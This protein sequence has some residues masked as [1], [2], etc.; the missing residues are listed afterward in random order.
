MG[1]ESYNWY[2]GTQAG[3]T[4]NTHDKSPEPINGCEIITLEGC[5]SVSDSEGKTIFYTDG[6]YVKNKFNENMPDGSYLN[7]HYS[8][9]QSSLIAKKPGSGNIYYVFTVDYQIGKNGFCYSLV[10]MNSDNSLGAVIEKNIQIMPEVTEKLTA[11]WHANGEDIWI[12]VHGWNN[13]KFFS[14]LLTEDGLSEKPVESS[15]GMVHTGGQ[16]TFMLNENKV[17]YMRVSPDSKKLACAIRYANTVQIFDFDNETGKVSNPIELTDKKYEH[18]YGLEFSPD[19]RFLYLCKLTDSERLYQIDLQY[20]NAQNIINNSVLIDKGTYNEEFLGGIQ[21]GPD[22]KIYIAQFKSKYLAVISDPCKKGLDCGFQTEAIYLENGRCMQGLPN[23]S[24]LAYKS[25]RSEEDVISLCEGETLRLFPG[26]G[27]DEEIDSYLWKGPNGFSSNDKDLL[28]SDVKSF[29][30]GIYTLEAEGRDIRVIKIFNV[31]IHDKPEA[32]ILGDDLLIPGDNIELKLKKY[33]QEYEYLWSTGETSEKIIIEKPGDYWVKVESP[34]GC[35]DTAYHS[36]QFVDSLYVEIAGPDHLCEGDS[37]QLIA[38]PGGSDYKYLWSTGDTS[39]AISVNEPGNY[40]VTVTDETGRY[41]TAS[42]NIENAGK[43][44][45]EIIL[46]DES[47]LCEGDILLMRAY[48]QDGCN[49]IWST[50]E[51]GDSIIVKESGTY[52]LIAQNEYGC[53]N[54][55]TSE[56]IFYPIPELQIIPQ[57]EPVICSNESIELRIEQGYENCKW[58]TGETGSFIIVN[59]T[60]I[61][62]A[63]Y[64]NEHGC[65]AIDSIEIMPVEYKFEFSDRKNDSFD[66]G[67]VSVG[68]TQTKEIFL[69]NKSKHGVLIDSIEPVQ[70]GDA[71]SISHVVLPAELPSNTSMEIILNFSPCHKGIHNAELQVDISEPCEHKIISPVSGLSTIN[72]IVWLPDTTGIIGDD[73]F[74]IPLKA[75]LETPDDYSLLMSYRA[76]IRYTADMYMPREF[77]ICDLND[78]FIEDDQRVLI[79]EGNDIVISNQ[80]TTIGEIE[81][82]VLLGD[83]N[84]TPLIISDFAYRSEFVN[85]STINGRLR[86]A[87]LCFQNGSHIT[88]LDILQAKVSPN[89]SSGGFVQIDLENC[90]EGDYEIKIYDARG[91]LVKK[92]SWKNGKEKTKSLRIDLSGIPS[93]IYQV[94]IIGPFRRII[95]PVTILN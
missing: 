52:I 51:W 53:T 70:E 17:G 71:F 77:F 1:R 59:K 43:P 86:I 76:E 37:I 67:N 4:F 78:I 42:K 94:A 27:K 48:K 47:E 72:T 39:N 31:E 12:I 40:S 56:V 25:E 36:V 6:F 89:P 88:M 55:D 23:F 81:G 18:P 24:Q 21:A 75:R 38:L 35:C 73:N 29:H 10:D 30:S 93:G 66:F 65:R 34:F 87:G 63:S 2:F 84:E 69:T 62:T 91:I 22:G 95:H 7:G 20:D 16:L 85:F 15:A 14:F 13:N 46:Q 79:V 60:G 82:T 26:T 32:E 3:I 54:A 80:E 68:S 5:A 45:A 19:S 64:I 57:K 33:D 8:A 11:A 44:V 50:G 92:L 83:K 90:S 61:Y 49:Y 74:R 28:I 9:T 41:G 58:S